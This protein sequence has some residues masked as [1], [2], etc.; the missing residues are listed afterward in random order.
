MAAS[1][2]IRAKMGK[3]LGGQ[4]PFGYKWED[5]QLVPDPDEAPVRKYIHELFYEHRRKKTV[6]GTLN[7]SGYRTRSGSKFSDT[8]IDRLLKDPT[9]KGWHR[10]NYTKS[11]GEKEN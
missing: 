7:E 9:G 6:A 11:L 3:P 8:T 10:L 2:P 5:R 4:A 1:V